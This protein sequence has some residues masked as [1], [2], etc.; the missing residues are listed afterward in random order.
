MFVVP[1]AVETLVV[2]EPIKSIEKPQD[3]VPDNVVKLSPLP[4]VIVEGVC[5]CPDDLSNSLNLVRFSVSFEAE[6]R[7]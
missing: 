1:G 3:V 5:S 4:N 2:D 6:G 7:S